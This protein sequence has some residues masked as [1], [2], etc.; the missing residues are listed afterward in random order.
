MTQN[1][2]DISLSQTTKYVPK[3]IEFAIC[4]GWLL[5]FLR[6]PHMIN[7]SSRNEFT[8]LQ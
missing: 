6:D 4:T 3:P 2:P 8:A 5:A 1:R 7:P